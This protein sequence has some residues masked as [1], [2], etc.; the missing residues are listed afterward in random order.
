MGRLVCPFLLVSIPS[1]VQK[2]YRVTCE[3]SNLHPR[4]FI[5]S[6]A[7]ITLTTP[8]FLH[9]SQSVARMNS[10]WSNDIKIGSKVKRG[11]D[12]FAGRVDLERTKRYRDEDS[13]RSRVDDYG[14]VFD[15][16]GH[17][18]REHRNR[19]PTRDGGSKRHRDRSRSPR[20]RHDDR[21]H[22]RDRDRDRDR[23]RHRSRERSGYSQRR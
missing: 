22:E 18:R 19:S 6:A 14:M 21:Y 11:G 15:V 10:H 13:G 23:R 2:G 1:P 7:N 3:H 20:N 17:Q 4:N 8:Y 12:G 9:S 16:S 5:F